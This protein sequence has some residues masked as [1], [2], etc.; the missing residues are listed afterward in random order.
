MGFLRR[1]DEELGCSGLV[2]VAR[3]KVASWGGVDIKI[4]KQ[5]LK[6]LRTR[7][8]VVVANHPGELDPVVLAAAMPERDDMY[9]VV[10]ATF[11]GILK[12]LDEHLIPVYIQNNI[13]AEGRR[14]WREKFLGWR[15]LVERLPLEEE[16]K[17]NR[18][19][20]RVASEKLEKGGLV[21]IYPAANDGSWYSGVGYMLAGMKGKKV[22]VVMAEIKGSNRWSWLKLVPGLGRLL[23]GFKVR[24]SKPVLVEGKDGKEITIFLEKKYSLW[25][26]SLS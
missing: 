18:R 5:T 11:V 21:V 25:T 8:V 12:N 4:D 19:S 23:G 6:V 20:I 24:F 22:L 26:G 16:G 14:T 7:P 3:E 2:A 13:E 10:D 17:R 15:G 9:F 1:L